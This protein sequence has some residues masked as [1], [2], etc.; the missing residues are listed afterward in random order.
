M[1]ARPRA[2]AGRELRIEDEEPFEQA[3]LCECG[4]GRRLGRL[5]QW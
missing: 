1:A 2:H 4:P 5:H 3:Q